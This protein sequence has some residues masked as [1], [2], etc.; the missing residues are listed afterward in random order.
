MM[1]LRYC[2]GVGA[3]V[4]GVAALALAHDIRMWD[5][6]VGRG[7]ARYALE[8]RDARWTAGTWLPRGLG[9]TTLAIN[10]DLAIRG[11]EQRFGIALATPRGFD[12]GRHRAQLRGE[13]Y[14]ELSNVVATGTRAQASRAGNLLGI[15]AATDDSGSD[16][17]AAERL[18]AETFDSAIRA[19]ATNTDAKVNLELLLR[20]IRVVGERDGGGTGAG[21]LGDSL[22]G[23][24]S[25][26]PGSGY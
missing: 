24:G 8:A 16:A 1:L 7:D 9:A 6:A 22:A 26:K 25:G 19:D 21:D 20:R 5:T 11:A 14:L 4:L 23:A 18:A 13:A 17:A 15:L 12:N 3:V 10:D 2:L